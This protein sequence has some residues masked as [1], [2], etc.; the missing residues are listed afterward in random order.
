M[1]VY[2]PTIYPPEIAEHHRIITPNGQSSHEEEIDMKSLKI[3]AAEEAEYKLIMKIITE[4]PLI[5]KTQLA[6]ILKVDPKTLRSR[7]KKFGLNPD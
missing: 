4:N 1:P 3:S 6:R 7:L 2:I 5:T